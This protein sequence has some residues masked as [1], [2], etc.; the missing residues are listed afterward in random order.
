MRG[1]RK[2]NIICCIIIVVV[3]D[4]CLLLLLLFCA[5]YGAETET[6]MVEVEC[7]ATRA[8]MAPVMDSLLC[9]AIF[10][11]SPSN[12]GAAAANDDDDNIVVVVVV[13]VAIVAVVGCLM[14]VMAV[15][16]TTA[17]QW[18]TISAAIKNRRSF[19]GDCGNA[20]MVVGW[21]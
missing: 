14:I 6:G 4:K 1:S 16:T 13:V 10:N 12:N 19:C 18:R 11:C 3:E 2:D 9:R 17:D 21:W 20:Q 15:W 5:V 8:P 7:S